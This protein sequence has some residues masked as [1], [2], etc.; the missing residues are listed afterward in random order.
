VPYC[1]HTCNSNSDCRS[2]YNCLTYQGQNFCFLDCQS[3]ADCI[4]TTQT[5]D[6][7][8]GLCT[9]ETLATGPSSYDAG[10]AQATDAGRVFPTPDAGSP[11]AGDAGPFVTIPLTGC[12]FI[13]YEAPVSIDTQTFQ[14]SIDTGSTTTAIAASSCSNCG[15]SPT[16]HPPSGADTGRQTSSQYGS[17][18][19]DGEVYS[20]TVQ[21]G[22][23]MPAVTMDFAGITDQQQF[24]IPYLCDGS[25]G[26]GSQGIL[27]LGPLSLDTIGMSNTDAYFNDLVA[28]AG[29]GN[30]FA[31]QLCALGGNLWFGGYDT[32]YTTSA[33]QYTPMV[34]NG[35]YSVTLSDLGFNGTSLG[36]SANDYGASVVDTGT[37]GLLLPSAAYNKLVS[38]ISGDSAVRSAFGGNTIDSNFFQSGNCVSP[39]ASQ[40]AADLDSSLPPLYMTFPGTSGGSFQLSFPATKSYFIPSTSGGVT[41][42]CAGIADSSSVGTT[43]IG[44]SALASYVIVFDPANMQ[45]GFASGTGCP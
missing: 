2:G 26:N 24:F 30:L 25:S 19:W 45:V 33:P 12:A 27:G 20:D 41:Q 36:Y 3:S 5:C 31:V 16:Y 13:G 23:E 42:Y 37:Y 7:S 1:L 44:A 11:P 32:A 28:T 4:D 38:D 29:I 22:G 21:V 15:V 9:G 6:T 17:G 18:S 10:P 35:Y 39:T 14:M 43:I 34:N 40:T 8:T